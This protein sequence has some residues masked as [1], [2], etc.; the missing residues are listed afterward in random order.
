MSFGTCTIIDSTG[1]SENI[2]IV[3]NEVFYDV[4]LIH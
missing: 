2:Y 3:K 1:L 4:V